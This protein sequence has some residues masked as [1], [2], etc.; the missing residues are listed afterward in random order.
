M[1]LV[2]YWVASFLPFFLNTA[3]SSVSCKLPMFWGGIVY[4]KWWDQEKLN[5]C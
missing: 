3:L 2:D 4:T 5:H 1:L